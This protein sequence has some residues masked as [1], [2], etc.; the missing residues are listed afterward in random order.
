MT[1]KFIQDAKNLRAAATYL[2]E[3][4]QARRRR[5]KLYVQATLLAIVIGASCGNL[6]A[7]AGQIKRHEDCVQW[8]DLYQRTPDCYRTCRV[9]MGYKE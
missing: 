2:F 9:R 4:L 6:S 3:K 7:K 5:R 1:A 8:C